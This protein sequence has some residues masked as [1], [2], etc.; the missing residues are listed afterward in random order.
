[1]DDFC[2][3]SLLV[4]GVFVGEVKIAFDN[5][6]LFDEISVCIGEIDVETRGQHTIKVPKKY[7]VSQ[8]QTFIDMVEG[9]EIPYLPTVDDGLKCQKILDSLLESSEKN[10]WIQLK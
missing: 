10:C 8:E 7:R 6:N 9:K 5:I 4:I 1:M 3:V 2:S